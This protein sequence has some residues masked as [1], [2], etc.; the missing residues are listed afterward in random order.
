MTDK[1]MRYIAF[2]T[3]LLFTYQNAVA[4][5]YCSRGNK[6]KAL[7]KTTVA[8]PEEN[9][10]D[11]TG[12]HFDINLSN[13]SVNVSG[14]VTISA[15]TTIPMF[16]LYAFELDALLTID[17]VLVNGTQYAVQSTGAVRKVQLPFTLPSG[18][19][20]TAQVFYHG[21]AQKG[22][23]QFFTG[24]LNQVQLVS[25]TNIMY[26]LSDPDFADDWWPCKQSLQDKIDS[27]KMW[28]TVDDSLK[29]GSNGLLKNTTT[30]P[31]NKVRYEWE[32]K[33]PIVYYLISVAVAPYK[34]H[35]YYMHFTDGSNDSMLI[36]N[37]YYDSTTFYTPLNIS[38]LDSTGY[39]VDH[40]SK[41]YG[42]YPFYQEKYGHCMSA[43]SGGMEHQTMTTLGN[44]RTTL[45]AHEL[46]HQW[47]GDN[48]TY[49]RWEDIWLSE[50]W[51]TY[52]E[53]LFLE[54][55]QGTAAAKIERAGVFGHVMVAPFGS[56]WVDD[57]TSVNRIFDGRLT[58]SKGAAVAH[59]LRYMAPA[60]SLFFKAAQTYQSQYQ[61]STAVT[62]DLKN[63]YEQVYGTQLD[64]FFD[65]WVYKQ[66]YPIFKVRWYQSGT[67]VLMS[68]EQNP[69]HISVEAFKMPLELKLKSVAGDTT[70]RVDLK[71]KNQYHI[72]HWSNVMTGI[73]VDPEDHI[74]NRTGVIQN[75]S[76]LLHISDSFLSSIKIYPNPAK[77][78]WYIEGLPA[79]TVL[80]LYDVTGR[81]VYNTITSGLYFL[82]STNLPAGSYILEV[83]NGSVKSVYHKLI[84]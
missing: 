56:V 66:G 39:M 46:G 7:A 75:D 51:A 80:K 76:T 26:S 10:Y 47:W 12:L 31:G 16:S 73:E 42:K 50:G 65:Q 41:L 37:F 24:G 13:T 82:P 18:T 74:V 63:V 57:T 6:K 44:T 52:G 21:Q 83:N 19:D 14:N 77:E 1:V 38:N 2:L 25:G 54:H 53:Q 35:N 49:A 67:Q 17:S 70:I 11:V 15:R 59:M 40:F 79:E 23:G 69:S 71:S 62:E 29:A 28:V 3:I 58:Y 84:K 45:I 27:V 20:F 64:T 9:D 68:I 72:T 61:Y 8:T 5:K 60:D 33:Y 34:E 32:T 55:F 22:T 48:V 81:A 4:H 30:M 78:G 43:L 36:Q